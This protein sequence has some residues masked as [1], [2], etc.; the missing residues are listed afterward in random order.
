MLF[1]SDRFRS[2]SIDIATPFL[3][4]IELYPRGMAYA[5]PFVR[6]IF[7]AVATSERPVR[8]LAKSKTFPPRPQPQYTHQNSLQ[9]RLPYTESNRTCLAITLV[10]N[11][12]RASRQTSST[13]ISTVGLSITATG[14]TLSAYPNHAE[15]DCCATGNPTSRH[16]TP[17]MT[18]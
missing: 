16:P 4:A 8:A 12:R 3:S 5:K 11:P 13:I 6:S 14:F 10:P 9:H 2:F 7:D 1:R 17:L 15:T 18:W